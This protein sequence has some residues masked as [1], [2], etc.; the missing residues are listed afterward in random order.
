MKL[1][2]SRARP[3]DNPAILSLLSG[4][5]QPGAVSLTFERAPDYFHG[6]AISCEQPEVFVLRSASSASSAIV[7]VFDIGTR[8][9]YINGELKAVRYFHDLR[10]APSVR[11]SRALGLVF[12]TTRSLMQDDDLFQA[13]VLDENRLFLNAM[14]KPRKTM[15]NL[16]V[17]GRIETSLI[18]G[19]GSR[20]HRSR[21]IDVRQATN[22][23]IPAMQALIDREGPRRQYFHHHDLSRLSQQHPFYRGLKVEDFYLIHAG[24]ELLGMAGTWDQKIFKQTRIAGYSKPVRISRPLYNTWARIAGGLPLPRPGQCF[25]YLTL[26]TL[27][28]RDQDPGL[29]RVLI[30]ELLAGSA[31]DYD[32]LACGFFTSDP[33]NR[34]TDPFPRRTLLSHHFVGSWNRKRRP[35][36]DSELVPYADIARL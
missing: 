3:E 35:E 28:V 27:I 16:A 30:N 2:A 21:A 25:S 1:E 8:Q 22:A 31:G 15:P 13:V 4:T 36:L 11:G 29:L 9:L 33:L 26:H 18:Y 10:L 17:K 5:P 7:G 20:R 34:A 23:D 6:A 12:Q 32:A 14:L 24:G 19:R